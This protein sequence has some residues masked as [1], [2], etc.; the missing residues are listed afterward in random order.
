[1][2]RYYLA[3]LLLAMAT[4][5]ILSLQEFAE[6]IETYQFGP[7][8]FAWPLAIAMIAAELLGG[9]AL[10]GAQ[11]WRRAGADATFAVAI[12]W[13]LLATQA[14]ARG[15]EVENCG[16]FGAFFGQE[17]RW[18]V[19]VQDALFVASAAWLWLRSGRAAARVATPGDPGQPSC[20]NRRELAEGNL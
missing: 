12:A 17:L 5:Q 18:Y 13:T 9:I 3:A 11:K 6:I 7:S 14:F 16:C 2:L 8:P 15:L 10:L 1:M 19:L 4:G 20:E